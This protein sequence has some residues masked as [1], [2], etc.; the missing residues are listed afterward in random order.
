VDIGGADY[1][2]FA[3]DLLADG[4]DACGATEEVDVPPTV[5]EMAAAFGTPPIP[6]VTLFGPTICCTAAADGTPPRP[7]A[8]SDWPEITVRFSDAFFAFTE[9]SPNRDSTPL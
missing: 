9:C 3:V 8:I 7:L 1:L 4:D 2:G 6:F 5:C